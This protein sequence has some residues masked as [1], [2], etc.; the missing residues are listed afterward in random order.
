MPA[1]C[2]WRWPAWMPLPSSRRIP[3]PP[4]R[5][6]MRWWW[7][8]ACSGCPHSMRRCR[9]ARST[10]SN[11]SAP[12]PGWR[13]RWRRC[14]DCLPAIARTWRRTCS[15][16]SAA[17]ARAPPLACVACAWSPTASRRRCRTGRG[18]FRTSRCRPAG[19]SRCCAG[20]SPRSMAT[21]PAGW[22]S[23]A[24]RRP[25]RNPSGRCRPTPGATTLARSACACAAAAKRWVTTCRCSACARMATATTARRS[26]PC[27]M[28][29]PLSTL[30]GRGAWT[31]WQAGWTPPMRGIRWA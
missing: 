27:G 9:R 25:R 13:P 19:P 5:R 7:W 22:W 6:S 21:R 8:R 16:R 28:R 20:R 31:W 15:C 26:A 23:G 3:P 12:P 4:R 2:P 1:R 11:R 17:L 18:S 24:A 29:R 30:A 14:P 10:S